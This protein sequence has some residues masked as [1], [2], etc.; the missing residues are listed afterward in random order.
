MTSSRVSDSSLGCLATLV[1]L[2]TAPTRIHTSSPP[3]CRERKTIDYS[4]VS[5][6]IYR[7]ELTTNQKILRTKRTTIRGSERR[8]RNEEI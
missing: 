5:A 4:N 8:E 3:Q 6:S 1:E 7:N 2:K